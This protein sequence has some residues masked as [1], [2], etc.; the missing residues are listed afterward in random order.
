MTSCN[1]RFGINSPRQRHCDSAD[2]NPPAA[3][4][5]E[6]GPQWSRLRSAV[7]TVCDHWRGPGAPWP[8]AQDLDLVDGC[9]ATAHAGGA[10]PN[11][12]AL[13]PAGAVR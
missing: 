3:S 7:G 6:I 11:E 8:G 4:Y 10:D 12:A 9:R 5:G 1:E 2:I 13:G